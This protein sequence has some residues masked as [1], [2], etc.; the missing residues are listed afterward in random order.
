MSRLWLVSK[1]GINN[2]MRTPIVHRFE[3]ITLIG[4][5]DVGPGDLELALTRAPT[6]VA[7]DGGAETALRAGHDP[8]AV[9]GDLDSLSSETRASI[10][11]D[12]IFEVREQDSTDF[13]KALRSCAAPLVLAVGFLGGR[14]DHQLAALSTLLGQADRAC[15]LIGAQEIIFHV[16]P[17]L[18]LELNAGDIVSL[19][20]LAPVTGGSAGLQWPIDGL[21]L[22]PGG[23][24]GTSNRAL[25]PVRLDLDGPGLLMITPRG[26]LDAVMQA[27]APS[28]ARPRWQGR[29]GSGRV[30]G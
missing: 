19:F 13:D 24:I 30:P 9:I 22:T 12:R 3:P 5:G 15:I 27:I 2:G 7:A 11:A 18:E 4:G 20:P 16:P 1:Y 28:Q 14:V 21:R 17:K 26:S 8:V 29:V 6:L 25:G 23:R 10:P